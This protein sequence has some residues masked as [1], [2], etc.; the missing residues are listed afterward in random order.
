MRNALRDTVQW[1]KS[2]GPGSPP[3]RPSAHHAG[4]GPPTW[5]WNREASRTSARAAPCT[6]RGECTTGPTSGGHAVIILERSALV[7][8]TLEK[9]SN[10]GTWDPE[11]SSG[12]RRR[13]S[14]ER[15]QPIRNER[16]RRSARVGQSLLRH[17]I[18]RGPG[19][20]RSSKTVADAARTSFDVLQRQPSIFAGVRPQCGPSGP[21]GRS[22]FRRA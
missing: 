21:R 20:L 3:A 9:S 7:Q 10:T 5:D 12:A 16:L 18:Q 1:P 19:R 22:S 15:T 2:P 8:L 17:L 13:A 4:A 14:P 11:T 6:L